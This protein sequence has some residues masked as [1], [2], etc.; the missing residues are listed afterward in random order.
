MIALDA[1][2]QP[3]FALVWISTSINFSAYF[4]RSTIQ[5]WLVLQLTN[6][7]T[8]VG[9]VNG[10]PVIVTAPMSFFAGA[11][12]DRSDARL[13][14]I[15]TRA[16]STFTCFLTAFL[17]TSQ[18]I[19]VY[20]LLVL[21][22]ALNAAFYLAFPAN[23]TYIVALVGPERLLAAN[24]LVTG[25]G[26][27][28]NFIGPSLAGYAA[29]QLGIDSVYYGLGLAYL[30][31]TLTL[32]RTPSVPVEGSTAGENMLRNVLAGIAYVRTQPG[33]AWV[34]YV[35]MLGIS[36]SPFLA[37]LPAMAR[38]ELGLGAAGFGLIAGSQG[39]GSLICTSVFLAVGE[40]RRKGLAMLAGAVVW[41]L[42]M[43]II[44][45]SQ[46]LWQAI[47]AGILMGFSPP[48]WMNSAQTVI[49]TA[50]PPPMRARMA[51]L[52]ALSF[53]MVPLGYLLGGVLA[54]AFGPAL[55]LQLLGVA[56]VLAHAPPLF[57]RQ[58]RE[59]G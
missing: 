8:W 25:F 10:L 30:A 1:L 12:T 20:Q 56:G 38:D 57:S 7:S 46:E 34:F 18:V 40:V 11:I 27:G 58:F 53:Q 17:I 41:A 13:L 23:Q 44:G 33:L 26:F 50:V 3:G 15:W 51:A 35:A 6:S 59:I 49:M 21:A 45:L 9:L 54:D 14:I 55:T 43:I 42:G 2:R 47:A 32:L 5:G 28:F 24:S 4:L 39:I 48:L 29:A 36:G 52:F 37:I 19:D 22:T 31:A 16:A